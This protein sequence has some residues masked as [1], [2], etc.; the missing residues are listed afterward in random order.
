MG[1]CYL[2]AGHKSEGRSDVSS[3]GVAARGRELSAR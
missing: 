1:I 2:Y 3:G